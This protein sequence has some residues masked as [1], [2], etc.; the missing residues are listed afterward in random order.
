[1]KLRTLLLAIPLLAFPVYAYAQDGDQ[2][3]NDDGTGTGDG[4]GDGET[5]RPKHKAKAAVAAPDADAAV[6]PTASDHDKMVG[7]L[8]V[9]YLGLT[10]VP[11]ANNTG[12]GI[13]NIAAPVI[14]MR[15]WLNKSIGIDAG[16]GLGVSSS[17]TTVA[18]GGVSTTAD[19]PTRVA[20]ALHGGLPIALASG[21][22]YTFELIPELNIAFATATLKNPAAG[23]GPDTGLTGI[24]FDV[25]AR[26]GGE[27]QFG[28]IGIP[29]LALQASIGLGLRYVGAKAAVADGSASGSVT[30]LGLGTA[31]LDAPWAIF[32]NTI[33][34]LYYF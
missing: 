18:A 1:M 31:V 17:S 2:K 30:Q 4:D 7:H 11:I 32:T 20:F 22:H 29:E 13:D 16:L 19:A 27:I 6:D 8:A 28:F 15:Y 24:R 14:G 10:Q 9:G 3:P 25:G 26:I 5:H 12:S 23:G 33:S 21:K 34:A